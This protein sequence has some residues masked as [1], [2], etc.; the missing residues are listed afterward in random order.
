MNA[1]E[2][3]GCARNQACLTPMQIFDCDTNILV[4]QFCHIFLHFYPI[5]NKS[6]V[7]S[8]PSSRENYKQGA[9]S[10]GVVKL[11]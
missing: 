3:V 10:R 8:S 7:I 1:I 11:R 5:V 4:W 2:F 6:T 9:F